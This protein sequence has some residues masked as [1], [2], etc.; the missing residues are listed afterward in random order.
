MSHIAAPASPA[1]SASPLARR[2]DNPMCPQCRRPMWIVRVERLGLGYDLR[3]LECR[4]C[5]REAAVVVKH[6]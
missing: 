1:V 4:E 5:N 6:A 3:T 2:V